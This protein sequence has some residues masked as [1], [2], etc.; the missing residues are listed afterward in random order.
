MQVLLPEVYYKVLIL[1]SGFGSNVPVLIGSI[2][3][4]SLVLFFLK[5][6]REGLLILLTPLSYFY[7]LL[8]K[9]VFKVAR[10]F[11][12]PDIHVRFAPDIYGFPSSHVIIYT[13]FFGYL[14]YLTF[15]LKENFNKVLLWLLRFIFI[16]FL[17]G[18]GLSRYELLYHS[19]WDVL[20]GYF[21]GA[22]YL[23]SLV[24]FSKPSKKGGKTY[25]K[26]A[27]K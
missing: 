3:F 21:F 4:A 14:L 10:P 16:F 1:I 7:S 13:V 15:S 5:F 17:L 23:F 24:Y 8:L 2:L 27:P 26:S 11:G 25:Q 12:G 6:R 22:I 9:D 19:I 18:V 20:G